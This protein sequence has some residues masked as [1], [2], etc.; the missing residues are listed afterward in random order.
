MLNTLVFALIN[1]PSLLERKME[2]IVRRLFLFQQEEECIKKLN[3]IKG[4]SKSSKVLEPP[5]EE[6]KEASS[7]DAKETPKP[8]KRNSISLTAENLSEMPLQDFLIAV[9]FLKKRD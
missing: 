8:R 3:S 1:E 2:T 9:D 5:D 4:K 7:K 6:M